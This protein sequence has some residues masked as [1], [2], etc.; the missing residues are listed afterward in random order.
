MQKDKFVTFLLSFSFY[1]YYYYYNDDNVDDVAY[2]K[3]EIIMK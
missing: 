2:L 1:Y 3:I